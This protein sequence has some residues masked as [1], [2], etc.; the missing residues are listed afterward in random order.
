MGHGSLGIKT[1]DQFLEGKNF[2]PKI[3]PFLIPLQINYKPTLSVF[4]NLLLL[5]LA[6]EGILY[7]LEL[8]EVWQKLELSEVPSSQN[9]KIGTLVTV[10]EPERGDEDQGA[11]YPQRTSAR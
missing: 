5:H 11:Y 6:C 3:L 10:R 9:A 7:Q 4:H 2:Y 8:S 1:E